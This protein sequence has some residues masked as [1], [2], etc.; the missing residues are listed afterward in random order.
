VNKEGKHMFSAKDVKDLREKTG[1]GMMDCKKALEAS[2]GDMEKAIDWLRENGIAK[3]AKKESRIAAEGLTKILVNGNDAVILEVNSE[4]DFVAK[5]EEF[6][7]FV[8]TLANALL[9]HDVHTMEEALQINVDGVTVDEMV[10]NITAKIG[11]KISFRRFE[12]VTKNSDETFGAY[13]HMGGKIGVLTTLK[14]VDETVSK[15]V[16][17][18]VAAMSPSYVRI[19]DVP[20]DVVERES[21]VLREQILN[22]GKP[23]DRVEGILKGKLGK[24]Y[25]DICLEEQIYIKAENKETVKKFVESHGG[26]IV[27]MIRYK[28]GD[29]IEKREENFAE[30]VMNQIKG[31]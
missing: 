16:A 12:R 24:F 23:A 19:E 9:S 5:N 30:E 31:E 15:D 27:A 18:H 4:T 25:Q 28:V 22:E 26:E 10:K 6:T 3:A 2:S 7:K 20:A 29:G 14:N 1:A 11:E 8:D 17:M 21:N 13:S